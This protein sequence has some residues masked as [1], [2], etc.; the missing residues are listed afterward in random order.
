MSTSYNSNTD[1]QLSNTCLVYINDKPIAF[2]KDFKLT[3]TSATIDTTS[4]FS[5]KFKNVLPGQISWNITSSFFKTAVTG[6]TSYDTLFAAQM[7]GQSVNVTLTDCDPLTFEPVAGA[8]KYSG[9]ALITS[10]DQ[11]SVHD[12]VVDCSVTLEGSGALAKA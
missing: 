8:P 10:L 1:L 5:G 3:S 7:A 12:S 6:D 11:N 4:K 9:V 2:S